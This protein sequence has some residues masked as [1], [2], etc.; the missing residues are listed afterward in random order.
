MAFRRDLCHPQVLDRLLDDHSSRLG[1]ALVLAVLVLAWARTTQAFH[2]SFSLI[3]TLLFLLYWAQNLREI[4]CLG[5][6]QSQASHGRNFVLA[7]NYLGSPYYIYIC[8]REGCVVYDCLECL[9]S[10]VKESFKHCL[11]G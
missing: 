1:S 10:S 8:W 3:L 5:H 9:G 7:L 6:P 2:F 4:Q 11:E